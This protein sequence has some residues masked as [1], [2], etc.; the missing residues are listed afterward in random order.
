MSA[1][2]RKQAAAQTDECKEAAGALQADAF[3]AKA[4]ADTMDKTPLAYRRWQVGTLTYT[5]GGL[6]ILFC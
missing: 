6:V 4:D 2:P 1:D 5:L 3:G